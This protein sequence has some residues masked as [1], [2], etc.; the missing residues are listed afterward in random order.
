VTQ[1]VGRRAG[2]HHDVQGPS[3][4]PSSTDAA[5]IPKPSMIVRIK[6]CAMSLGTISIADMG[7]LSVEGV[8]ITQ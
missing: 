5:G 3:F 2:H 7:F 4:L 6:S 1:R 8:L